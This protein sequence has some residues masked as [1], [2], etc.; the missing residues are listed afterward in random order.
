MNSSV[1]V[2]NRNGRCH[3]RAI[4]LF[5]CLLLSS[6]A[7]AGDRCYVEGIGANCG[8][9][10][11]PSSTDCATSGQWVQQGCD[12]VWVSSCAGDCKESEACVGTVDTWCKGIIYND[13]DGYDE[14]RVDTMVCGTY[15]DPNTSG[16]TLNTD[17]QGGVIPCE[18]PCD[19][20]CI[21]T[22]P[23]DPV[24]G[25]CKC[26]YSPGYI[27]CGIKYY[28]VMTGQPCGD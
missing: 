5:F 3:V 17:F 16:C 25:R 20:V 8:N 13:P 21:A 12:Y 2:I 10:P 27:E 18:T 7:Y 4:R 19:Q 24:T 1:R 15:A 11:L 26:N 23:L 22:R 9:L 28:A 6:S 14:C